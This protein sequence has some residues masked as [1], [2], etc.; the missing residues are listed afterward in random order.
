MLQSQKK[1]SF[2][3]ISSTMFLIIGLGSYKILNQD[4]SSTQLDLGIYDLNV[5]WKPVNFVIGFIK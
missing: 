2:V 5:C 4:V 3:T 1:I